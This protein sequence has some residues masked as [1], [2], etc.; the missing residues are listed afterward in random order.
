MGG[1]WSLG[2]RGP[3]CA[4][5]PPSSG[6]PPAD[7]VAARTAFGRDRPASALR[8]AR[9][10]PGVPPPGW[11]QL[12]FQPCGHPQSWAIPPMSL[13]WG[14]A[15]LAPAQSL[16]ESSAFSSPRCLCAPVREGL[17]AAPKE[18]PRL[19]LAGRPLGSA[20][21]LCRDGGVRET[22]LEGALVCLMVS[23]WHH[24]RRVPAALHSCVG[25]SV[26]SLCP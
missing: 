21:V 18:G 23:P 1:T 15:L 3:V 7:R 12:L 17:G 5:P 25:S 4:C 11:V 20:L 26:V 9:V 22:Q 24:P 16:L 10:G 19:G 6:D 8:R 14:R 13:P 2:R